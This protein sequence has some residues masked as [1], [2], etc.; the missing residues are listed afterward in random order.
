MQLKY[1]PCRNHHSQYL[2]RFPMTLSH[3]TI[4]KLLS[5]VPFFVVADTVFVQGILSIP[6]VS[7]GWKC[8]NLMLK[9]G[10]QM[11]GFTASCPKR[12]VLIASSK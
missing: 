2:N 9:H 10:M 4:I 5:S 3:L 1:T 6:V 7:K 12:H 8:L 11:A